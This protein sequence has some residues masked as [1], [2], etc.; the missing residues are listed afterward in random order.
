MKNSLNGVDMSLRKRLLANSNI[1]TMLED[2]DIFKGTDFISTGVPILDIALSGEIGKGL[3]RGLTIFAGPSKHFKSLLGLI[4]IR[5][6]MEEHPD[7]TCM[8]YDSEWG[9][10]ED[11]FKGTGID[12]SR[13]VHAGVATLEELRNEI[14]GALDLI[15]KGEK[16]IF[17][18]DSIGNLASK[19]EIDDAL[20]GSDKADMTRAKVIKSITR[21][22]AGYL[23]TKNIPMIMIGHTYGTMEMYSKPILSGGTGI[24]YNANN[25]IFIGREQVKNVKKEFV[26]WQYN[27]KIEKSRFVKEGTKLP[28]KVTY[29]HWVHKYSGLQEIA[30]EGGYIKKPKG[31]YFTRVCVADDKQWHGNN[32]VDHSE[33]FWTPIFETTDFLE[34]VKNTFQ[35]KIALAKESEDNGKEK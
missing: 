34:Y 3:T 13:V 23:N 26:G 31:G 4:V 11:Y 19:K 17:F 1:A 16:I 9:T 8:F 30:L 20:S 10:T 25:I 5:R 35:L 6:Y 24:Y 32:H 22:A 28:F 27:L 33:D 21:I 7:A 2:S 15:E 14:A 18:I 29:D 12:T